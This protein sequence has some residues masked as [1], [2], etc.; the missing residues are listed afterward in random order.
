MV[1]RAEFSEGSFS[2][3]LS[4][5]FALLFFYHHPFTKDSAYCEKIYFNAGMTGMQLTKHGGLFTSRIET[6]SRRS[7][8]LNLKKGIPTSAGLHIFISTDQTDNNGSHS[9]RV[10]LSLERAQYNLLLDCQRGVKIRP[11]PR[12]AT[13]CSFGPEHLKDW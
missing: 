6:N 5:S 4:L 12:L 9:E 2:P 3:S 13:D 10:A 8:R 11:R 7:H 1:I